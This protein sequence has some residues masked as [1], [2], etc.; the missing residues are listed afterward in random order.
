[1]IYTPKN[2]FKRCMTFIKNLPESHRIWELRKQ[3]RG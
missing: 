2:Y 3:S 1:M